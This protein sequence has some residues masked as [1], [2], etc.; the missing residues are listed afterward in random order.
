[1]AERARC[2]SNPFVLLQ[3]LPLFHLTCKSGSTLAAFAFAQNLISTMEEPI[4]VLIIA[5]ARI[6]AHEDMTTLVARRHLQSLFNHLHGCTQALFRCLIAWIEE[7]EEGCMILR[8]THPYQ[9]PSAP[10]FCPLQ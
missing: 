4:D 5:N 7:T 2:Q 8:R 10:P 6:S 1:M 3:L 9:L